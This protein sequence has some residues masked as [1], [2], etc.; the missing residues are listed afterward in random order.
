MASINLWYFKFI[1]VVIYVCHALCT[2]VPMRSGNKSPPKG[3]TFAP[4]GQP[5][6]DCGRCPFA[7]E[8]ASSSM[9]CESAANYFSCIETT[10]YNMELPY[11]IPCV[12]VNYF[13]FNQIREYKQKPAKGSAKFS[14]KM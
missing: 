5:D 9:D 1:L 2:E 7:I 3:T 14:G 10:L 8:E 6:T 13:F 12:D 11:C 4:K